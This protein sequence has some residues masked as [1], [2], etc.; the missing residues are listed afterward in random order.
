MDAA[1]KDASREEKVGAVTRRAEVMCSCTGGRDGKGVEL[2][3]GRFADLP[4]GEGSVRPCA[5]TRSHRCGFESTEKTALR[6]E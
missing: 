2:H 6:I 3:L 5:S 1:K 4:R